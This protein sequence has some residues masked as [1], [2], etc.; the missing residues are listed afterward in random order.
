MQLEHRLSALF[1]LHLHSQV[2]TWLPYIALRQLARRDDKYLSFGIWCHLYWRLYGICSPRR[3]V[4]IWYITGYNGDT[5]SRFLYHDLQINRDCMLLWWQVICHLIV[6]PGIGSASQIYANWAKLIICLWIYN[7]TILV[8]TKQQVSVIIIY[9]TDMEM[10]QKS[11]IELC[12][13][14]YLESQPHL[15]GNTGLT[16]L[17]LE[18]WLPFCRQCFQMHFR[19]WTVLYFD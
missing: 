1:Q 14:I 8:L 16:H 12:K 19:E 3:K 13:I 17:Y 10:F 9:A 11:V 15:T 7:D 4:D 18:K 6:L 5:S 2:N